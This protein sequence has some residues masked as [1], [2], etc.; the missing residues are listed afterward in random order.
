MTNFEKL[1]S[2]TA[3]ELQTYFCDSFMEDVAESAE[4]NVYCCKLCPFEV[5]CYGKHNG[6]RAWLDAETT[7]TTD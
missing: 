3:D 2:M 4:A 7:I 6:F 5:Y 1:K